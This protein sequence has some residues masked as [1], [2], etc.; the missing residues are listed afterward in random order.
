MLPCRRLARICPCCVLCAS[1]VFYLFGLCLAGSETPAWGLMR[2]VYK[3]SKATGCR[4]VTTAQVWRQFF[5]EYP[6]LFAAYRNGHHSATTL[7]RDNGYIELL[8]RYRSY[9]LTDHGMA[10][11]EDA[12][13]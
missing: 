2:A 6:E 7:C 8:P 4:D 10:F 3:V 9:R 12:Y 13:I 5:K 11:C 1:A